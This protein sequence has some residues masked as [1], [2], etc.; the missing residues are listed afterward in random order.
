MAAVPCPRNVIREFKEF[1]TLD[2]IYLELEK[3]LPVSLETRSV[4]CSGIWSTVF[5]EE[6]FLYVCAI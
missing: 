5:S 4:V 3:I 1:H 2:V 6:F